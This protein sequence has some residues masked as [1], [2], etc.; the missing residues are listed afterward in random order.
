[1][2][3]LGIESSCDETSAAVLSDGRIRSNIVSSQMDHGRFGGVVPELASRMHLRYIVPVVEEALAAAGVR[4][5]ELGAVAVTSGP[6]LM[7]SLMVGL[8]FAR[9]FAYSLGI[10]CLAVNHMEGHIYANFLE[11]PVPEFPFLCLTVS[12]GH[13]QLVLVREGFRHEILGQTLD[14]AAGEAFDKVAK[15]LGLPFPGGPVVD[16][17]AGKGNP[18]FVEFPRSMMNDGSLDFSFSGIKTA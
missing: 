16:R 6:G 18:R 12:G 14:D 13:T 3:I 11:E 15:M 5:Q 9:A 7:G 1:M 2:H 8:N 17:L 10:P 4:K